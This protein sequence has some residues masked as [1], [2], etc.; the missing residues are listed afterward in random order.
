MMDARDCVARESANY[1]APIC[2]FVELRFGTER[3]TGDPDTTL[4]TYHTLLGSRVRA[5]DVLC[6]R[7]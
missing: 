7:V 2:E 5:R 3:N 4:S 6:E 1:K